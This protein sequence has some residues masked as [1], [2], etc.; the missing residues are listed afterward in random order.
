M[1]QGRRVLYVRAMRPLA[2]AA[3]AVAWLAA[4]GP[5]TAPAQDPPRYALSEG[6]TLELVAG[7]ADHPVHLTAPPGDA[8]LF[9][10]EQPGKI[11]ILENGRWK[12]APFLDLTDRVR[13]GGEQGLLSLAFHPRYAENGTFFVNY[14]DRGGD[15]RVER[16]RVSADPDRADPGSG[17]L[18]I[19]V[20]Q[21]YANH[22]GGHIVFGPDG[23]LY[24]AMGDGGSGGDPHGYGQDLDALLGKLLR[25]DVDARKPYAIPRD[26][27]FRGG[28]G[29][30]EI[31][32]YGLRNPWRIAFDPPARL[33]YIADVGQNQWE[34]IDVM[35]AGRGGFNYG[36]NWMEG[37]RRFRPGGRPP[38]G[39]VVPLVEYDHGDGCSITGGV[40]YRGRALPQLVGHYVFSDYCT[41][42]V[43]SF[44]V[45]GT[46]AVDFRQWRGLQTE[47]VTS[48]G[49][50]G[51]GE[52]Y[53]LSAPRRVL[54]VRASEGARGG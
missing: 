43:R 32:A 18:V 44:R 15:T 5:R 37:S 48:F 27:P 14:T 7:D 35:P 31:W 2:L 34:E 20:E 12:R 51:R 24:V 33:L 17:E 23:M 41:G 39:L 8:R 21:P 46:R 10:V 22:N 52:L 54:R 6:L 25:L 50:D 38:A 13:S 30:A 11:R 29:R 49:V 40:V 1:S 36:W 26:N 3:C 9:V 42:W 47:A 4:C 45:E 28:R 16:Y 19:F 53:V